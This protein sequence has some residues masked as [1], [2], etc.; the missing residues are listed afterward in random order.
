M[1]ILIFFVQRLDSEVPR[2]EIE[3]FFILA[4]NSEL[5]FSW[6]DFLQALVSKFASKS[7]L[8]QIIAFEIIELVYT[9]TEF[10]L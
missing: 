6:L 3:Y 2:T 4:Q 7:Y 5:R 9:D 1:V 10:D 8:N